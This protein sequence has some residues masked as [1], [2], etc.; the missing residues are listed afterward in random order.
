MTARAP[1]SLPRW[2]LHAVLVLLAILLGLLTW[3]LLALQVL[4]TD[5]GYEFLKGQGDA[6]SVRNEI[7]P[8][9]RGQI[10]DRNGEP[11]AISTPVVSIWANPNEAK[12]GRDRWPELARKLGI[13]RNVLE[14]KLSHRGKQ[15]V[16]LRRHLPPSEAKEIMALKVPGIFSQ[17][18]YRRFYPAGEV[19]AHLLGF[20]DVDD[21]GQEGLEL[22]YDQYLSGT[23]GSKKVLKELGGKII[24]ELDAGQPA[25]PGNDLTLSID[26]RLQYLAYRELRNALRE[27]GASAG[28]IVMLDSQTGE[29]LAMANQPSFNPNNRTRNSTAGL[30]NRA[31]LDL[32]EPGSTMK[33]LTVVAA[34]ESGQYTPRTQVDAGPGYMVVDGK[35]LRDPVNYGLIDVTKIITK[36]SQV[37]M[38]RVALSLDHKKLVD[39]FR[40]FGLG[41]GPDT[42]FPGEQHGMLPMRN[43]WSDIERANLAFGYGLQVTSLQLARAYG[44]FA[45]GG[46]LEPVSLLKR[47]DPTPRGEQVVSPGVARQVVDMMKTV[48]EPGGTG[49][50]ARIPAYTVAGKTG[51]VHM[52][53]ARG[54]EDRY[55]SIFAGLAPATAPRIVTVVVVDDASLGR[56]HG[57]D[58]AAPVFG[59]VVG[60]AMRLLN[61][62]P[63]ALPPA[64]EAV[65]K[66]GQMSKDPAAKNEEPPI[67]PR[68]PA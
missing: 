41:V 24:R 30:R 20:T 53:G 6:R 3:R 13:D 2:R 48:V 51:T 29:V 33:P 19:T 44:V 58:V 14:E 57:G 22:A 7:I 1:E 34:L 10:V 54:Y 42:G 38:T 17:R 32:I 43:R 47:D 68:G 65:A 26:L 9:H 39:V 62:A 21:R 23:P 25:K 11:L 55:H 49:V 5:R 28:S 56:Y 27:M 61:I 46:R 40:R 66:G 31:M 18:E 36:S 12:A 63:D 37:G 50:R 64:T 52:V 67:E 35:V 16:Y 45:T 59:K 60:G 15:F 8:A 4:D